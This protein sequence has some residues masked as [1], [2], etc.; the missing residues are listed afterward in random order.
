MLDAAGTYT[1]RV[2]GAAGVTNDYFLLPFLQ[3]APLCAIDDG[4]EE[5]DYSGWAV[6]LDPGLHAGLS[7]CW[8]TTTGTRSK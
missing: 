6:A 2:R 1:V 4:L 5:N 3:D 8:A 7:V